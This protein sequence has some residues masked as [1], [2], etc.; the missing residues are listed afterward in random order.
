MK[1]WIFDSPERMK[2]VAIGLAVLSIVLMVALTLNRATGGGGQDMA[3][4]PVV[5]DEPYTG[6]TDLVPPSPAQEETS[7]TPDYGSSAG[8]A[9]EAVNAFLL[10]DSARFAELAQPEAVEGINEAPARPAGQEVTGSVKTLLP[11]PTRQQVAV[12]TTDGNLVLDMVVIDGAWKVMS[13]EY[14]R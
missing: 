6:P 8:I 14:G 7:P 9:L 12:P 10:N 11:G 5:S 13:I 1:E 2:L 4:A 3:P